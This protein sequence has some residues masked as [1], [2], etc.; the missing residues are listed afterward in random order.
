MA[1]HMLLRMTMLTGIRAR[2]GIERRGPALDTCAEHPDHLLKHVIA[3]NA[4]AVGQDLRRHMAV[5]DVPGN[6]REERRFALDLQ[7][8]LI[9]R[10]NADDTPVIERQPIAVAQKGSFGEI[11]QKLRAT[12]AFH[13]NA[14]AMPR[15]MRELYAIGLARAIPGGGGKDACGTDHL[16]CAME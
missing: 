9:G 10:D 3:A 4:D 15:V 7:H 1:V 13:R 12:L 14:P 6:A 2:L 11:E 8:R 16:C 5:A